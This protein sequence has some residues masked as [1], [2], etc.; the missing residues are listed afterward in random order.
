MLPFP[1]SLPDF[2]RFRTHRP[3]RCV[4]AP[5]SKTSIYSHFSHPCRHPVSRFQPFP[6]DWESWMSSSKCQQRNPS[7]W[8]T[9][10]IVLLMKIPFFGDGGDGGVARH[11]LPPSTEQGVTNGKRSICQRRDRSARTLGGLNLSFPVRRPVRFGLA[12]G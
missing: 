4:C 11:R 2:T 3:A 8:T 9:F 10:L 7:T 12:G 6:A 1:L 5:V